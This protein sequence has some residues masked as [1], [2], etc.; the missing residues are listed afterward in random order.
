MPVIRGGKIWVIT[1]NPL[2]K[3]SEPRCYTDIVEK[4]KVYSLPC[5]RRNIRAIYIK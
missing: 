5:P 2:N 1:K 4:R 3:H